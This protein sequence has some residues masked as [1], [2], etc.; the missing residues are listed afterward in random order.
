LTHSIKDNM[1]LNVSELKASKEMFDSLT[2]LY[3]SKNASQNLTLMHQIR[4]MTMN[5]SEMIANYFTRISQIKDPL[6]AIGDPVED[7][8]IVTIAL[9]VFPSSW[10][11]F[12]QGICARN[13]LPKFN[14]LWADCTQEESRLISKS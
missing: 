4:N 7:D 14:N 10:D 1:I 6:A 3:E 5:K 2:K 9:N 11:P 12:V 8:E 13:K